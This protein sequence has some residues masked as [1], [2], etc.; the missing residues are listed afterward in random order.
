MCAC[1]TSTFHMGCTNRWHRHTHLQRGMTNLVRFECRFGGNTPPPTRIYESILCSNPFSLQHV[2]SDQHIMH[3]RS[4]T[5]ASRSQISKLAG[6]QANYSPLFCSPQNS[7]ILP[8][9]RI[10]QHQTPLWGFITHHK[11]NQVVTVPG[12][13]A[14]HLGV[15]FRAPNAP[16]RV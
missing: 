7:R 8:H 11:P 2:G 16:C 14:R 13:T 6:F 3:A 4:G 9:L 12:G 15:V 10:P 1:K 5:T